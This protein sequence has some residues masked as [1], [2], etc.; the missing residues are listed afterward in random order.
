[1][2]WSRWKEV[3]E[4]RARKQ[5]RE[6]NKKRHNAERQ[7]VKEGR[8]EGKEGDVPTGAIDRVFL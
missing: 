3:R 7:T 4:A 8:K 5:K 6:E 1:L 2:C